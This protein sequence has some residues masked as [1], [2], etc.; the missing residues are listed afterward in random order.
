MLIDLNSVQKLLTLEANIMNP[1]QTALMDRLYQAYVFSWIRNN[2]VLMLTLILSFVSLFICFV[3]LHYV[4]SQQLWSWRGRSVH[5][6][7]LF[8]GQA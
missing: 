4:P 7:T 2:S 3:L 6:T 8:P 1:D 5:L